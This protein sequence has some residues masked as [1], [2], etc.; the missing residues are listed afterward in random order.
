[1]PLEADS[2]WHALPAIGAL[3]TAQAAFTYWPPM[4]ALFD[5]RPLSLAQVAAIL[6]AGVGLMLLQ[7]RR[8]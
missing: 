2:P 7:G 4:Q 1:M 3:A 8:R 6:A 5:T